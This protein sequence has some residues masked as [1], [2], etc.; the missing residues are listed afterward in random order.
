[1]GVPFLPTRSGLGTD[2]I[3]RWGFSR[4]IREADPHL[5]DQKVCVIDNPFQGHTDTQ[6]V[7][8]V[9][10]IHPDVTVIHVQ[11]ANRHGNARIKGLPFVDV[12]Q[13]KSATHE[14]FLA[15]AAG[16]RLE[17]LKADP[18][19]GYARNLDRR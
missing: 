7:V 9:P 3:E 13:A 10:A 1:M 11:K 17:S 5:P 8:L 14:E 4:S 2:I 15:K 12:E 19:T 16:N 18:V 6:Q